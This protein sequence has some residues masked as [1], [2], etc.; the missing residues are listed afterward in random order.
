MRR[1]RSEMS[2][3]TAL[4]RDAAAELAATL[5]ALEREESRARRADAL[6]VA[7]TLHTE[8]SPRPLR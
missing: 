2:E 4:R 3:H 5:E 7:A 1:L 8:Q 6:R